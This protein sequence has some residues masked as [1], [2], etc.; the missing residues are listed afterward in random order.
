MCKYH[1]FGRQLHQWLKIFCTVMFK[2]TKLQ[3]KYSAVIFDSCFFN[4]FILVP[5]SEWGAT[6]QYR[7]IKLVFEVIKKCILMKDG[8]GSY[9][10]LP[11][12]VPACDFQSK[13]SRIPAYFANLFDIM[14]KCGRYK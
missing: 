7:F 10:P 3:G 13:L 5:D 6:E 14:S 4:S 2:R 12:A 8:G 1:F 9:N 11:S